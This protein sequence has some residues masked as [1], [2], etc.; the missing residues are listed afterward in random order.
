MIVFDL[1]CSQGH[2]FEGWFAS[3][4][5]YV[6]QQ[7]AKLV[8]CPICDDGHVER[9]PSAKV[10]VT[11]APRPAAR[12]SRPPTPPAAHESID[13]LPAAMVA[14]LRDAVRNAE[15]VGERF[16]EEARKIHYEEIPARAIRGRASREEADALIDEGIEFAA[17]PAFL[18]RESH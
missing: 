6:R 11:K 15:D 14:R 12:K 1:L 8:H 10:R 17:L 13:G 2:S 18:T 4:D 5:E 7:A 3:N 16:P 9:R